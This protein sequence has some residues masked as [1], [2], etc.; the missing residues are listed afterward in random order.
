MLHGGMNRME[1]VRGMSEVLANHLQRQNGQLFTS[2][3]KIKDMLILLK[4]QH[5]VCQLKKSSF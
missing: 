1:E 5:T 2:I 4:Y 3:E